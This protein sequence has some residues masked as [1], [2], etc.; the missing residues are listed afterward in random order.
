MAFF[1]FPKAEAPGLSPDMRRERRGELL[2]DAAEEISAALLTLTRQGGNGNFM[3]VGAGED[4]VQFLG[5]RGDPDVA[6]EIAVPVNACETR[7]PKLTWLA[8][9]GFMDSGDLLTCNYYVA[10]ERTAWEAAQQTVL[11]LRCLNG[12]TPDTRVQIKLVL[13]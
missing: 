11:L 4:Y 13:E 5:R 8:E 9:S 6:C 7:N 12:F 10:G 2:G 1:C 3:M